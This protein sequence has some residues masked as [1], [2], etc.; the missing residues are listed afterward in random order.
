MMTA[1]AFLKEEKKKKERQLLVAINR[2]EDLEHLL[3]T[4]RD[5][6]VDV[7]A[8]IESLDVAINALNTEG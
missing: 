7:Q 5:E 3:K 6:M 2:C 1:L 8:E 4:Q